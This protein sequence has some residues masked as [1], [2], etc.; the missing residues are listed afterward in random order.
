MV[1][2]FGGSGGQLAAEQVAEDQPGQRAGKQQLPDQ[3][4]GH[5]HAPGLYPGAKAGL[6]EQQGGNQAHGGAH[7][8]DDH[9]GDGVGDDLGTVG[10]ANHGE[11][12]FGGQLFHDEEFQNGGDGGHDGQLM[13]G[14]AE[15]GVG[16]AAGA[17]GHIVA[18]HAIDHDDGHDDGVHDILQFGLGHTILFSF[19]LYTFPLTGAKKEAADNLLSAASYQTTTSN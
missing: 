8:T 13:Q 17:Q 5:V 16:D 1:G 3:R 9:R 18:D 14:H 6:L 19:I 12:Q 11:G 2:V 4:H 15:G 7:Q 10:G